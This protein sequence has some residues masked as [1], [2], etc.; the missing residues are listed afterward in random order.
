MI[1]IM[2]YCKILDIQVI[3]FTIASEVEKLIR[4]IRIMC[5]DLE[6]RVLALQLLIKYL[7]NLIKQLI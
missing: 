6:F 4:S 5:L 2:I 3:L 1:M 7:I